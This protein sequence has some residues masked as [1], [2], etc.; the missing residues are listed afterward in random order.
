M[1]KQMKKKATAAQVDGWH[2][3]LGGSDGIGFAFAKWLSERRRRLVVVSRGREH[4]ALARKRLLALGAA[5]VRTVAGDVLQQ[6][7]RSRLFLSLSELPLSTIFIGGPSPLAGSIRE[8]TGKEIESAAQSCLAYP[9]HVMSFAIA[10]GCNNRLTVVFLS[11]SASREELADHPFFLSA[12]F[13]RSAE[14]TLKRM[15]SFRAEDCMKLVILRPSVVYTRLAMAY[16]QGLPSLQHNDSLLNR[17][18]V[19]FHCTTVPSPDEYIRRA[20]NA[21]VLTSRHVFREAR[22]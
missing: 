12:A 10:N 8:I 21:S 3:V 2:L 16:A 4:L 5:E 15:A 6:P 14:Q 18:R 17:L 22:T 11:S 19:R 13:R 9:V 20:V 7:F 1:V